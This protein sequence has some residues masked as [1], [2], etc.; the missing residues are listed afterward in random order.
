MNLRML[1]PAPLLHACARIFVIRR[2]IVFEAALD[3]I[4]WIAARTRVNYRFGD[5]S[6]LARL[7]PDHHAYDAAAKRYSSERLAA[8]DK[9]ILGETGRQ[10]AFYG[11]A[12]F[13]RIDLGVRNL[14]SVGEDTVASYRLFTVESQRGNRLCSAYFSFLEEEMRKR[15]IRRIVSWVEAHNRSS[16]RVHDSIGFRRIGSIWHA[17]LLSRSFFFM[18]RNTRARLR[19]TVLTMPP[20]GAEVERA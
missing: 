6:D 1:L 15:G 11:W 14:F 13:G 9:L 4:R 10:V 7:S 12:M 18:P 2:K 20:S 16:L 3:E 19:S 5:A 17:R 8:G